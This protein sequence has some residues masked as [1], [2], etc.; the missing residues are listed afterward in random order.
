MPI[1]EESKKTLERLEQ[2]SYR[3]TSEMV[4][5]GVRF[6]GKDIK[7]KALLVSRLNTYYVGG[8]GQGKTQ[9]AND[10]CG[11]FADASCYAMGRA[12]FEPSELMR[13]INWQLLQKLQRGETL[14][15][16]ELEQ[17][18]NLDKLFFYVDELNRCPAIVQNYFFDFFD[19]KIVHQGKIRNLG[20]QGYSVGFASGNLGDG[21][22]VGVSDSDRALKDRMHVILGLDDPIFRPTAFDIFSLGVLD[23][24]KDPRASLPKEQKGMTEEIIAMNKEF[25]ERTL[26]PVFP[27]LRVFFTRGLDWLDNTKRNSKMALPGWAHQQI[28]GVR[29]DTDEG[30]IYP[31]SVRSALATET[32]ASGLQ[33]VAEA[34]GEE[35]QNPVELYLDAMKLTVSYSGTLHPIWLDQEHKGDVYSA[36]DQ[37]MT[38]SREQV[39]G[40]SS[41]LEE[42]MFLAEAG[43][44]NQHLLEEI[45]QSPVQGR[46]AP[47]RQAIEK[48]AKHREQNPSEEGKKI[49]EV[50]KQS[51]EVN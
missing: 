24:K 22:Y 1:S 46:W 18:K 27:A 28:E 5:G 48:Y 51:H 44:T 21:E 19:G 49:A 26:N 30:M 11:I 9:L 7:V 47:V 15:N 41:K 38:L 8:T 16:T 17:L 32:L 23:R 33:F 12:D 14:D 39:L 42:A 36:F 43:Q 3:D 45:S 4:L 10:L 20:R 50:I 31:L 29:Y 34:N 40:K 35:V 13:Q 25:Q 6:S 37:A 2:G